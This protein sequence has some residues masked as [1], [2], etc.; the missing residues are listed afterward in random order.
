MSTADSHKPAPQEG[1]PAGHEPSPNEEADKASHPSRLVACLLLVPSDAEPLLALLEQLAATSQSPIS[2]PSLESAARHIPE[3]NTDR[4]LDHAKAAKCL[5]VSKSTMYR[6]ASQ[7]RIEY[8]KMA[9]RLEYRQSAIERLI[10]EQIRPARFA[11]GSG[12]I[13]RSALSSGK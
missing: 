12:G 2:L 4:W 3:A 6:Y 1:W 11:L 13:M 8:R 7:H 9:G 10:E 5:G